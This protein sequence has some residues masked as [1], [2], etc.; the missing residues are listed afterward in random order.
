MNKLLIIKKVFVQV[1]TESRELSRSFWVFTRSSR[2]K[3]DRTFPIT[4]SGRSAAMV[5]VWCVKFDDWTMNDVVLL[6]VCVCVCVCSWRRRLF[7]HGYSL[8]R[9][10]RD[11]SPFST[12]Q[13]RHNKHRLR[14]RCKMCQKVHSSWNEMIKLY[15]NNANYSVGHRFH[16]FLPR[17]N[18]SIIE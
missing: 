16:P 2:V 14:L 9:F 4:I 18:T 17:Y 1:Q 3:N 5:G 15:M 13:S 8:Y 12:A 7:S 10:D 11:I 6:V